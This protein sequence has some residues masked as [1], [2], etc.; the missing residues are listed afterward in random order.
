MI[1]VLFCPLLL[2]F[3]RA[4]IKLL[5]TAWYLHV[6]VKILP[7]ASAAPPR[8]FLFLQFG[9]CTTNL[10]VNMAQLPATL[11]WKALVTD[12]KGELKEGKSVSFVALVSDNVSRGKKCLV[13]I[14]QH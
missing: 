7:A 13:A 12:L 1:R 9:N 4:T 5:Y 2:S 14:E 11:Q 10:F 8:R 3:S 6:S